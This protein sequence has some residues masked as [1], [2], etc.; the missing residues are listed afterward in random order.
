MAYY[1]NIWTAQ[2]YTVIMVLG[3]QEVIMWSKCMLCEM[4]MVLDFSIS[5]LINVILHVMTWNDGPTSPPLH[6]LP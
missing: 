6:T 4:S 1:P 3:L 5:T 2:L